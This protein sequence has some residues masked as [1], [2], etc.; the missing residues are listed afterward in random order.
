VALTQETIEDKIE[1]VGEFK[2]VQIRSSRII[3]DDGVEISRSYIRNSLAPC[4]KND[5]VWSNTDISGQSAEVQGICN[6]VWTSDVRSAYK[7]HIDGE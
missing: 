2:H 6:A 5:D 7:A 4:T 1:V 3:Y